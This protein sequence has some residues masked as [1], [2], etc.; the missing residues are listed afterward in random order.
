MII[1]LLCK[2]PIFNFTCFH[3][4][5]LDTLERAYAVGVSNQNSIKDAGVAWNFRESLK[6]HSHED[7]ADFWSKLC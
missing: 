3:Y 1:L 7:F 5:V 6:G 2:V 4:E